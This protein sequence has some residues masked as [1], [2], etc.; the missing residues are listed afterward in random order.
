MLEDAGV[1]GDGYRS[2]SEVGACAAACALSG[3]GIVAI[4]LGAA[5]VEWVR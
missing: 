4:L 5:I 1:R 3:A 2:P